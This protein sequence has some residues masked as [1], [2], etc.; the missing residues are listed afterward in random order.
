MPPYVSFFCLFCSFLLTSTTAP[1]CPDAFQKHPQSVI[2]ETPPSPSPSS[3]CHCGSR[4]SRVGGAPGPGSLSGARAS[5]PLAH[6]QTLGCT[7]FSWDILGSRGWK[8]VGAFA[9]HGQ[10][11]LMFTLREAGLELLIFYSHFS[12]QR[13]PQG[14]GGGVG[15]ESGDLGLEPSSS[16]YLF[17]PLCS[18]LSSEG[19]RLCPH[20]GPFPF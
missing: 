11:F 13:W 19:I 17:E 9:P 5:S 7:L 2:V 18:Q 12:V 10:H 15:R 3:C 1:C 4:V 6:L 14:Q 20:K 16:P 8:T